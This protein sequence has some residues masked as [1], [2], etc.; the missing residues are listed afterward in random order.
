[1]KKDPSKGQASYDHLVA[2]STE[3][4]ERVPSMGMS[5]ST[6][7]L[8]G[9]SLSTPI[10][11]AAGTC[12]YVDEMDVALDLSRIGAVTTKSITSQPREGN[13]PM[14]VLEARDGMLNSVGLAN[15]GLDRFL[16]QKAPITA[17]VPTTVIGSI[18]GFSVEEYVTVASAFDGIESIPIVEM[19]VSCPNTEDGFCATADPIRLRDHVG[20]VREALGNT[21]LFVKLPP[22]TERLVE[23]AVV[24]IEAGADGL[25]LVNT[26][27]VMSIDV[28]TRRSRFARPR[29]GLSGPAIHPLTVRLVHEVY[30]AIA[31]DARVPIIGL[32][33]VLDWRDAA[34]LILAGASAV[35]MGT[36]LFIDPR[37]PQHV[38]DGLERWVRDQGCASIRELVGGFEE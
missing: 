19:N 33:G 7:E 22:S 35:G 36:A 24:A 8:C 37:S 21:R 3:G 10:V 9:V 15:M 1:M 27:E 32:G 30:Q 26:L 18:A 5:E 31:R 23:T 38:V 25:T 4:E 29:E 2:G 16:E 34:E 20:A 17:R 11:L 28:E 12:G 6:M 13:A 14:R